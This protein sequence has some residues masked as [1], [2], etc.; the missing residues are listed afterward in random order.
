MLE[1]AL[2][3]SEVTESTFGRSCNTCA[4]SFYTVVKENKLRLQINRCAVGEDVSKTVYN[5]SYWLKDTK[6]YRA[7]MLKTIQKINHETLETKSASY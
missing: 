3:Q 1:R 6:D 7:L 5:C 4:H 2:N